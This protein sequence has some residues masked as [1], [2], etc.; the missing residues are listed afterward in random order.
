M[1]LPLEVVMAIETLW[2]MQTELAEMREEERDQEMRDHLA[3]LSACDPWNDEPMDVPE[4]EIP[5]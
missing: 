1:I 5:F 4:T 2:E 3:T